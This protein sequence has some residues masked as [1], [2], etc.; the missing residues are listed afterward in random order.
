MFHRL[1][2]TEASFDVVGMLVKYWLSTEGGFGGGENVNV[3]GVLVSAGGLLSLRVSV[4]VIGG[5]MT[6]CWEEVT[7]GDGCCCAVCWMSCCM[8]CC[9]ELWTVC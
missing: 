9:C 7:L 8:G 3:V 6:H 1:A 4:A 2:G 5:Y